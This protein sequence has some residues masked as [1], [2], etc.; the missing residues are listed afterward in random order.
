MGIRTNFIVVIAFG[1]ALLGAPA[2]ALAQWYAGGP[3]M[4]PPPRAVALAQVPA[5]ARAAAERTLGTSNFSEVTEQRGDWWD[6]RRDEELYEFKTQDATG[7][8]RSVTVDQ[9]GEVQKTR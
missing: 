5:A 6:H 4:P 1:A 2:A 8:R 9:D 3:R 7:A